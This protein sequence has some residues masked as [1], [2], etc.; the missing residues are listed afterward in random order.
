MPTAPTTT[1]SLSRIRLDRVV[2]RFR[3]RLSRAKEIC[4]T[5]ARPRARL[6]DQPS[7]PPVPEHN[8][9]QQ[10]WGETYGPDLKRWLLKPVFEDLEK[11]GRAGNLIVDIGSGAKPV[12]RLLHGKDG[13]KRILIDIAADN[14][15]SGDEQK[16]RLDAGAVAQPSAL[17]LRKASLRITRFLEIDPRAPL[18]PSLADTIV[19][20]DLLNY[21]DFQTVLQGFAAYLKPGGR[22]VITNLPMRGNQAL[23]SEKGLKNNHQL[24]Q[25]LADRHFEIEHKSFPCMPRGATDESE[26]LIVL[27][28]RKCQ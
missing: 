8:P 6:F 3:T 2:R 23:F 14:T 5:L 13:R 12:T 28:A 25:F 4:K 19:F 1:L 27:V 16:I 11:Q 18:N 20:S 7:A 26:E 21:V 17:S 10:Y 24:Y 15:R 22:I 9:W